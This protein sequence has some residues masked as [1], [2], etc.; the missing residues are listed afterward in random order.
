M[1]WGIMDIKVGYA[2]I[3]ENKMTKALDNILFI[4][5]LIVTG[6]VLSNIYIYCFF[7]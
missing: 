4:L 3:E 5:I 1:K 6:I 7:K 2:Y